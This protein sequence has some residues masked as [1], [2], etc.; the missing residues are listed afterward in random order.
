[1]C[2]Y[3]L[4]MEEGTYPLFLYYVWSLMMLLIFSNIEIRWYDILSTILNKETKNYVY[5]P[6]TVWEGF[7]I[8]Y[9]FIS[10]QYCIKI[11]CI[12][13][14]LVLNC[15]RKLEH[16]DIIFLLMWPVYLSTS[17]ILC[18]LSH[19]SGISFHLLT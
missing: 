6:T 9:I 8:L 7:S 3:Y 19:T 16:H 18:E 13:S 1:M 11:Y 15:T 10:I 2:A 12:W 14:T 5:L 4:Q 17:Y